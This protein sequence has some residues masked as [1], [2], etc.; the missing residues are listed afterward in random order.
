VTA[1]TI[2]AHTEVMV[3]RADPV[4]VIWVEA[5]LTLSFRTEDRRFTGPERTADGIAYHRPGLHVEMCSC[6]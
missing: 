3:R 4:A 1:L 2:A 5:P 6:S